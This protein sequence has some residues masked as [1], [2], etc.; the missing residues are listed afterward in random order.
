VLAAMMVVAAGSALG[1]SAG[2]EDPEPVRPEFRALWVDA[3]HAGIRSP[4]EVA[5]L[6]DAAVRAR[7]NTLFVQVRRRAD[8]LFPGAADPPLDDPAYDPSFD[9]LAAIVDR[10]H[11][12]GLQ[13][14]AWINA[15]PVWRDEAPPRDERHVFHR[16]GPSVTGPEAWLTATRD[17]ALKFPVGYFL[18]LG[19]P[20]AADYLAAVYVDVVRRYRVDGIHFDYIRYPETEPAL[21]RGA[22][23]GYNATSLERF[24][25]ASGR[26]D[27]PLPD[28]AAWS[29]WRRRQVTDL[30]RRVSLEAREVNPAIR[31]SAA[32]IAWGR[33]PRDEEE[34]ADVA[35]MQRVFQ[36]WRGWLRSGWLDL[37]VPMNYARE[38]DERVRGWFDGWI[39]WEKR[40]RRDRSLIVGLGA[41]L[42]S[43]EE[44]LAQAERARQGKGNRVAQGVSFFSYAQPF[45]PASAA[46]GSGNTGAPAI[47]A[48]PALDYLGAGT[49]ARAAL[50][51][52]AAPVP[53]MPWIDRPAQ[54]YLLGR[55]VASSGEGRDGARVR[56]RRTGWFRRTLES[57]ADGNGYFG[58]ARLSPGR[59]RVRVAAPDDNGG[60]EEVTVTVAVTAG[61]VTRVLLQD[62]S[63]RR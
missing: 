47:G 37:A 15:A 35:P 34:F 40:E 53:S 33:P 49:G 62:A 1:A 26:G 41:Y 42:N 7:L 30:V 55:V 60:D 44:V 8:V 19:H 31:V 58:L 10:A 27:V 51:T 54:G 28:D 17:G 12:A 61:R 29:A 25:R 32:V 18:D 24:R 56:I 50:F 16:H 45:R 57:E 3:F 9:A 48:V 14:H 39:E 11:A 20:A 2:A 23:V 43:P 59:Y 22:D 52:A 5:A 46:T 36:D 63:S 4:G 38:R 13:V 6:V 21:P